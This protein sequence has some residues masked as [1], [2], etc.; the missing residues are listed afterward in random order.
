M[1]QVTQPLRQP[2]R[3]RPSAHPNA[4]RGAPAPTIRPD[5]IRR[6]TS[7]ARVS[8]TV[9]PCAAR[10]IGRARRCT[11][12]R[13]RRI[14]RAVRYSRS[15]I[16][17]RDQGRHSRCVRGEPAFRSGGVGGFPPS[18]CPGIGRLSGPG[19][20]LERL[21]QSEPTQVAGQV[22]CRLVR[23]VRASS[24]VAI[25]VWPVPW[26]E[27]TVT[28]AV[29]SVGSHTPVNPLSSRGAVWSM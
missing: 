19:Q 6:L 5:L 28:V 18:P 7:K 4:R 15:V 24:P 10:R 3:R 20:S 22:S 9:I 25:C 26:S 17:G 1:A 13:H 11:A 29:M 27:V 23:Q 8:S 21:R 2:A 12:P 14:R 16:R